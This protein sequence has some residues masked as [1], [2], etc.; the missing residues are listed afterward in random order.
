MISDNKKHFLIILGTA[1]GLAEEIF[2]KSDYVLEPVETGSDY[3]HLSV[4]SAAAIIMINNETICPSRLLFTNLVY[5]AKFSAAL[6]R[7]NSVPS[8]IAIMFF[9]AIMTV[10]PHKKSRREMNK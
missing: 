3:N 1:W 2:E 5:A 6:F 8:N 10:K 7:I 9:L 4:R